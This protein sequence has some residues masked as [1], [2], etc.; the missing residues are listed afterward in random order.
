MGGNRLPL[1]RW[2]RRQERAMHFTNARRV[3]FRQTLPPRRQRTLA[4][5][6]LP[7]R[8]VCLCVYVCVCF[9]ISTK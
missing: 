7:S 9:P 2:G 1:V 8:V 5:G 6:R 3:F 4:Q